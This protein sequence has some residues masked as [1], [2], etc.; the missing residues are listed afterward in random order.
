MKK[1]LLILTLFFGLGFIGAIN[2]SDTPVA[3]VKKTVNKVMQKESNKDWVNSKTGDILFDGME[4][5]TGYKSLAIIKFTDNSGV[6]TVREN[7]V[8]NIY[9]AQKNKKM[10]KNT[11]IQQGTVHFD[12]NKQAPDEEFKFTTPTVVASIRGTSGYIEVD[13]DSSTNIICEKGL[14]EV[15]AIKGRKEKGQVSAGG[16][17]S[18][19]VEGVI[20]K[21]EINNEQQLKLQKSKQTE[22]KTLKIKT[23][24]GVLEIKYLPKE[25]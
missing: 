5:K 6:L 21:S 24:D 25:Q 2:L 20:N 10:D 3:V 18:V 7:C 22:V 15:E 23:P 14:I 17:L 11:I 13:K 12:V 16:S 1:T 4:V 8:A 9:A 19:S